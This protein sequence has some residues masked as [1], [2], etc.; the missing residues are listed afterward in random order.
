MNLP[1]PHPLLRVRTGE[2]AR[3]SFAELFFD[4]VYV[5]AVTQLSH[6]LLAHLAPLG[7][8]QTLLLWFAVWLGWQYTCWVSN[9]FDPE[10]LPI[11]LLLFGVML[12]ALPMAAAIP[13]AFGARGLLFALC[14]AGIQ[15]GR[16]LVVVL[17]LG[18]HH[19]LSPNFRRILGWTAISAVFWVAGGLVDGTARLALWAVAVLCE[20]VSPMFGFRLPGLGRSRTSDWTIEG[21]HLAERC[22]LFVIVALGECLLITGATLAQA[23][24]WEGLQVL[25][26]LLAFLSSLA[27]WWIYF[28]T[29]SKDASHTIAH[30]A[31][32]GRMGAYFH[33]LHVLIVAGLIVVAVASELVIAHPHGE[34][35]VITLAVLLGGPALYLFGNGLFRR[36]VYGGFPRSHVAGLLVLALL[37]LAAHCEL[38]VLASL[39]LGVLIAV[40][41]WDGCSQRRTPTAHAPGH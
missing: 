40:A 27:L 15:F 22:Q 4:L 35:S 23:G 39:V 34:A 37:V 5:F 29:S 1:A 28:D 10:K 41:V 2:E 14:Y 25:A 6:L 31:D 19:P 26:F 24:H 11:R 8:A 21:G 36:V 9:W 12:L 16:S 17:L 7:A 20:Y 18:R 33:Y 38:L 3:V 32:P 30:A 13:Q